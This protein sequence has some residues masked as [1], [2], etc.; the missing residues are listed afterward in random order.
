MNYCTLN[1][2]F[3][4]D[5]FV[6][7]PS[8]AS[9]VQTSEVECD[10]SFD[11][12]SLGSYNA[13]HSPYVMSDT[14]PNFLQYQASGKCKTPTQPKAPTLKPVPP[15]N[16]CPQTQIS[17]SGPMQITS[18]EITSAVTY[19]ISGVYVIFILDMFVRMGTKLC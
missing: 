16:R 3:G 2:A 18:R 14:E 13:F 4:T 11:V 1:E 5:P 19:I 8:R 7:S 6:T 10:P 12:D 17:C 9:K 15:T